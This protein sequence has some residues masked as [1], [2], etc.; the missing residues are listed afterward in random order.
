MSCHSLFN[1]SNRPYLRL[2]LLIEICWIGFL[3]GAQT[4]EE[5]DSI[6]MHAEL[7]EVTIRA[8]E[9]VLKGRK[10]VN[11][12]LITAQELT[13]AACCNLGESFTTNPSVDVS[14]SDAATG[15]RQIRLLGL[16]GTYVQMLTENVPNFR[17]AAGPYGLGYIP[18]PWMQ[19]IQISKGASSVKNGYESVSGQINVEMKKPQL[20]PSLAFN[21]YI[22]HRGKAELNADG[23]LHFGK[24]WSGALLLHGE[25]SFKSHD[26]NGDGFIDL[27]AVRQ[28][29]VMNRWARLSTNY[30][31]QIAAKYLTERR[32]SG[33]DEHLHH[34][35]SSTPL[36]KIGINTNRLEVFTKN[37][38]IFDRENQGNVALILAGSLHDQKA[39]Y[40]AKYYNV[41]QREI[42]ASLM[43]ERN[44]DNL[45]SLSTGLSLNHDYFNQHLLFSEAVAPH[46]SIEKETVGGGYAQYTL[47]ID[48][49]IILM[50]GMRY[51]YSSIHGSI[52]TPRVHFRWNQSDDL[53]FNLSAGLGHRTPHP[54][55][56]YNYLLAS[57]RK[58]VVEDN[59]PLESA[60]NFGGATTWTL[61][62]LDRKLTV[63]AEYYFTFFRNQLCVNFDRN[64]HAV[65]L[66]GIK[67]ASRSHTLQVE[68]SAKLLDDLSASAA[69]RLTDSRTDYGRGMEQRPL[70][71][72]SKGLI[73][74]GYSPRMGLWQFDATLS[75]NGG[76]RMP[77]PYLID[78]KEAWSSHYNTYCLLN[79]QATRNFR[80][81]SIYLGGENLT[82]FTQKNPIIDAANPWGE[83]FDATMI[84]GPLHGAVVYLGFRYHITK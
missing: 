16:S 6:L 69:Y 38:Y 33:Q 2:C 79:L 43:F 71:S 31:F 35:Q 48:S 14:Y 41:N 24:K 26:E 67:G 4:E 64:P 80:H 84:Y 28:F 17:G 23:N 72:R 19:S 9:G 32:K 1:I 42:Y 70:M 40:G 5:I 49:K 3:A 58:L 60:W 34:G 78:G 82:G 46:H 22:D 8:R 29:S 18:G 13:R 55:A 56:E 59:L 76:G 45:H 36:Y 39:D 81:W 54:L 30:V 7:N 73:S 52:F 62:V 66:Y 63:S 74:L 15:A 50:G 47:D 65:Y 77:Q 20:D 75:V 44:W 57:S 27:P 53:T 12:E 10:G 37:A 21:G 11:T 25:N 83:N 51:D 68:L 61:P